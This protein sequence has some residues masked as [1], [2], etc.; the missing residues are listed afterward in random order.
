MVVIS[1]TMFFFC[2]SYK[3]M[4]MVEQFKM[5]KVPY[6]RINVGMVWQMSAKFDRDFT[7]RENLVFFFCYCDL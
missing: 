7:I 6:W 5:K 3:Q 4:S 2:S 1:L